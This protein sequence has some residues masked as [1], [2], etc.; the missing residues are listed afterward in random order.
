MGLLDDL[1]MHA[2]FARE[3]PGFLRHRINLEQARASLRDGVRDREANF[4]RLVRHGVYGNPRSPYLPLLKRAHCEREDLETLVRSDGLETALGALR[5]AGVYFSFEEYKG[6]EPVVRGGETIP[7]RAE[8]FDNPYLASAY[9]TETGGSTSGVGT[10]VAVDLATIKAQ[11][12]HL[13]TARVVHDML[14]CPMAIWRG[15]LPD[16]TGIGIILRAIPYGGVPER[17]FTPTRHTHSPS[18]KDRLATAT[19]L[20]TSRIFGLK[21]PRPESVAISEASIIARWARD[22]VTRKGRSVVGTSV[23]LAVRIS[24][25]AHDEG[26]DL[27]GVRFMSGGEPFTAA[28]ANSVKRTGARLIPHYI[29]VDA[30]PTGFACANPSHED[31]LHLLRDCLALIQHERQ[32]GESDVMVNAFYFTSLRPTAAKILINVESDD[33]GI[34]EQRSCGCPFEALGYT[35]HLREIRSFGKLTGEGVTLV[36]SEMTR[37]LQ[38]VLPARFGGS[39]L[40]FQLLEEEDEQGLSRLTIIVSPRLSIA[41]DEQVIEVMLE[42]LGRGSVAANIARAFWHQTDTLRVVRAE[43]TWTAR[44]KLLPIRYAGRLAKKERDSKGLNSGQE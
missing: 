37:I 42:A 17:W 25:A 10:R 43:P 19:I 32:V 9:E 8:Q 39:P 23:S 22:A 5:E 15:L 31:D 6:R 12:P 35:E 29:S 38:E 18:L 16:P 26:I 11:V 36:G 21:V 3:L 41:R 4:L 7:I 14:D 1:R 13:M 34:V 30:G 33:Y 24:V 2:R 44:G 28:K 20:N 40:D 27:S